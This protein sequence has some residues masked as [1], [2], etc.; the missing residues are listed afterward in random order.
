MILVSIC[1]F[2]E[3][4]KLISNA[5]MPYSERNDLYCHISCIHTPLFPGCRRR[6]AKHQ[7]VRLLLGV[8]YLFYLTDMLLSYIIGKHIELAFQWCITPYDG[9]EIHLSM[10][11]QT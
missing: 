3:S 1:R 8:S 5:E 2:L 11:S 10:Y 4:L 6:V 9:M 7:G